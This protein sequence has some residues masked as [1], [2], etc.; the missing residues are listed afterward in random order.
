MHLMRLKMFQVMFVLAQ[1]MKVIEVR[2]KMKLKVIM[3]IAGKL[4]VQ[5][6]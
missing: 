4:T 6:L 2:V 3:E 1:M 5:L